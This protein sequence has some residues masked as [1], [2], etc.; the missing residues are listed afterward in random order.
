MPSLGH[1]TTGNAVWA[2]ITATM[3]GFGVGGSPGRGLYTNLVR[4]TDKSI[5]EYEAARLALDAYVN[6]P[7]NQ[8]RPIHE[9]FRSFDHLENCIE[10]LHRLGVHA[11]A[12]RTAGEAIAL[13]QLPS[14]KGRNLI[15][16]A[17]NA[18]QHADERVT[19]GLTGFGTNRAVGLIALS[20]R[21]QVGEGGLYIRYDWLAGWV[22][23]YYA[24]ANDLMSRR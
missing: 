24:L 17:R 8:T 7:T 4:L 10:S 23:R 14:E 9:L 18:I 21:L 15:R 19:D 11:K 3:G 1:L 16:R 12:L 22:E 5:E 2:A 20:T 13:S 6:A